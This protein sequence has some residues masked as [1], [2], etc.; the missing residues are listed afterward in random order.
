MAPTLQQTQSIY[1]LPLRDDGSPDVAGEYIYLPPP[2]DPAYK[3]RFVIEGTSSVCR[4]GSLW[5]NIPVKGQKFVR[6]NYTEYK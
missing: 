3:I 5:V 4:E 2:S 1:L 6:K